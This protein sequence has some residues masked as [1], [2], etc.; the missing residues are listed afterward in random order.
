MEKRIVFIRKKVAKGYES[1]NNRLRWLTNTA[2][3]K[4]WDEQCAELEKHERQL[5]MEKEISMDWPCFEI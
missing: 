3:E 2:R 1:L 4:W 5:Y